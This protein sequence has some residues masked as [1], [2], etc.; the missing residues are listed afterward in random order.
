MKSLVSRCEKSTSSIVFEMVFYG[1][2]L[3]LHFNFPPIKSVK[4]VLQYMYRQCRTGEDDYMSEIRMQVC[5]FDLFCCSSIIRLHFA[6]TISQVN[7]TCN[8]SLGL[9]NC[10]VLTLSQ[11]QI[12]CLN[13]S[14]C[15]ELQVC[16]LERL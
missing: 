3:H 11:Q 16:I 14:R 12:L 6:I 4:F 10:L 8:E 1:R 5:Y 9:K 15:E 7:R 13:K 2:K